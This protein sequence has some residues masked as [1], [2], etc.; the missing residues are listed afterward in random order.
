VKGGD[1]PGLT[2]PNDQNA[3][4]RAPSAGMGHPEEFI[5]PPS[6]EFGGNDRKYRQIWRQGM[7]AILEARNHGDVMYRTKS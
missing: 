5:E 2:S 3:Q 4:L 1:P 6:I 7:V